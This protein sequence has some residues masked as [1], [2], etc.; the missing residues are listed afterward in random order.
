MVGLRLIAGVVDD[1]TEAIAMNYKYQDIDIYSCSWGPT[2]DGVR[3]E[4]P[5][6]LLSLALEN[7][8]VNGRDGKGSVF[9]WAAG[10]GGSKGDNCN[11]D[12]YA[13]NPFTISIGAIDSN[14]ESPYYS[15]KCAAL[16]GI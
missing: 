1:A 12:G 13:N 16:I 10:N 7:G 11:Y 5:G 2:D 9:V 4:K 15:E 8:V 6:R 3:L 14:G